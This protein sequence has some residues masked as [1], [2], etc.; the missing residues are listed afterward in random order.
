MGVLERQTLLLPRGANIIRVDDVEGAFFAWAIVNKD[1]LEDLEQRKI[2]MY[3]TGA[4]IEE[5]SS[6]HHLGTCKL[7]VQMELCL[8]VFERI[9]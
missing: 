9:E 1:A 4:P 7:Y 6:L 2:E 3:K 8:Y 5:P